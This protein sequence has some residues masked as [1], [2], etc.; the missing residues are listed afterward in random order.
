MK[1]PRC[2]TTQHPFESESE[3]GEWT[4]KSKLGSEARPIRREQDAAQVMKLMSSRVAHDDPDVVISESVR[5]RIRVNEHGGK[6]RGERQR[7]T[8]DLQVSELQTRVASD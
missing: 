8:R 6:S 5:E 7:T 2:A 3:D 1:D 4:I